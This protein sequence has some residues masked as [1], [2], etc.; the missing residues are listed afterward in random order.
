MKG[1]QSGQWKEV[2]WHQL[3]VDLLV[4]LKGIVLDNQSAQLEHLLD[5]RLDDKMGKKLVWK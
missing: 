1:S 2:L 3:K 4:A 5:L